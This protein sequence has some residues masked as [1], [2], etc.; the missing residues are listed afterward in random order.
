VKVKIVI[1]DITIRINSIL[2]LVVPIF[3]SF[4]DSEVVVKLEFDLV[5][6]SEASSY[7]IHV[8]MIS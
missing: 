5:K 8:W 3:A 1:L 6:N 2:I 7:L 4:T